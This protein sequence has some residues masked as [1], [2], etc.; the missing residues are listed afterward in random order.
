MLMRQNVNNDVS[1]D[2]PV[3]T[4]RI[5]GVNFPLHTKDVLANNKQLKEPSQPV[6][7]QSKYI[8]LMQNTGS[9]SKSGL[10]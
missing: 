9:T 6:K 2:L 3:C 10:I 5:R 7:T 1:K 4:W 8:K